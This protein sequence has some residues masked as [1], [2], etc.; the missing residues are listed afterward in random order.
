MDYYIIMKTELEPGT[1]FLKIT[2]V[3]YTEDVNLVIEINEL[4]DSTFGKFV[5]ENRTKL[6]VG[7]VLYSSFFDSIPSVE[8][9]NKIVDNIEMVKHLPKR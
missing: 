3:A 6:Q 4:F 1:E 9:A 5:G 2:D 7:S 8:D